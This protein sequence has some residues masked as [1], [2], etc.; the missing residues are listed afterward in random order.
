M[1]LSCYPFGKGVSQLCVL[2]VQ[3]ARIHK[4]SV[5]RCRGVLVLILEAGNVRILVG[6]TP[7]LE[8]VLVEVVSKA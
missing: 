7:G 2:E 3:I 5:G 6:M 1:H 4:E 8:Y